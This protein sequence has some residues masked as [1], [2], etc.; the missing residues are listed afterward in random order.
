MNPVM[1]I[2]F[3]K[4]NQSLSILIVVLSEGNTHQRH[5]GIFN[6]HVVGVF[7]KMFNYM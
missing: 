4:K 3:G 2:L 1:D 7:R 5:T 6:V